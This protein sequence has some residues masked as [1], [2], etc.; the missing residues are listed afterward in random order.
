MQT[1]IYIG[2]LSW[3]TT[4]DSLRQALAQDG[5]TVTEIDIKKDTATGRSRGFAF[6]DLGTVED[7]EAAISSLDGTELDGRPIK[8]KSARERG[9]RTGG[10][11][12]SDS[13]F[14]GGGR[15]G[16]GGGGGGRRGGRW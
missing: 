5:R 3:D 4:E 10:Y 11:G 13:G 2:N 16:G 6:V 9:P 8:V 12:R 1:R 14:G 7:A 15:F